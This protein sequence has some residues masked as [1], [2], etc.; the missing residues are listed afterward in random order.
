MD[1]SEI[2][3]LIEQQGEAI[4]EFRS[5]V[6]QRI[7]DERKEREALEARLNRGALTS[8]P[9]T[10]GGD[11]AKEHKALAQFVRTGDDAEL[12][13]MS[14][15]S[16][17]DGGYTVLPVMSERMTT[18]LYDLSPMRTISRLEVITTGDAFEEIDDR[19]ESDA[20]WIGET[21]GRP[22]TDTPDI[23]K[24]SIPV[25]EIYALQTITQRLLDD[26]NRDMGVWIEGKI[27]DKFSRSEGTAFVTGDG[28]LKPKGFLSY[29]AVTDGDFTR[30]RGK[31]QY[32]KTGNASAFPSS[33][34]A[35]VLK[36]LM[37]TLRAPYRTGAVWLMNST[38]ASVVDK[39]KDGMG[40]YL[41]RDGIAAGAPPSLLGYPVQF[42]ENMP[43][44]GANEFPIAFGN[45]NLGYCIVEK[46]GVK[47]LRDPFTDKPNV[48]FYAY[49]RVGGGVANDDAIKLLKCEA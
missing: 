29:D 4:S 12:K 42:D 41:W 44:L 45:F 31:L 2:K 1:F 27:S 49:R 18:R 34:P 22:A 39:F 24:W 40:N 36:T 8:G 30:A 10:K 3:G 26:S 23:G 47:Y 13:S 21:A 15:G 35:D 33:N 17:P 11:P 5:H 19:D 7:D 6:D 32:V 16:D 28:V 38:T 48:L 25:H 9:S 20:T 14:V 46:A 37:Y 43:D